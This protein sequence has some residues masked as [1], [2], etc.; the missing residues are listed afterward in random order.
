MK[1]GYFYTVF[2]LKLNYD[3][4]GFLFNVILLVQLRSNILIVFW[5]YMII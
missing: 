5:R 4:E 2:N 1:E 3:K